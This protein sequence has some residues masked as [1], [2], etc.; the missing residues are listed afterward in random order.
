[1]TVE[2]IMF[3]KIVNI[4]DT[5]A[6]RYREMIILISAKDIVIN[7]C[8]KSNKICLIASGK[9]ANGG[10]MKGEVFAWCKSFSNQ[11]TCEQQSVEVYDDFNFIGFV[12][13]LQETK[14]KKK[15]IEILSQ[16]FSNDIF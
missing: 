2:L 12:N 8:L 16:Q 11:K 5:N 14:K 3:V 13:L 15:R 10:G 7:G 6:A 4:I 9:I 1:M